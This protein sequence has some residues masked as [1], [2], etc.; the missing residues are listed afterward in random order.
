MIISA[1]WLHARN[2]SVIVRFNVNVYGNLS[3]SGSSVFPLKIK[4]KGQWK[5]LRSEIPVDLNYNKLI[6]CVLVEIVP[7]REFY[8]H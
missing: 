5:S 1:R 8:L 4:G 7:A 6:M 2:F 3:Q